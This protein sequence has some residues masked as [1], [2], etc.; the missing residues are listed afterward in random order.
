MR[1]SYRPYNALDE[2]ES[3]TLVQFTPD[4]DYLWAAGF[5]S[6]RVLHQFNVN[7]PGRDSR[8]CRLGKTR[9]S[10]DGQKGLVSAMSISKDNPNI[11]AIGTYAPG[12]I[13]IYD[14]RS[15]TVATSGTVWEGMSVVGHGKSYKR[16]K[17]R[18]VQ[19]VNNSNSNSVGDN[20]SSNRNKDDA[21]STDGNWITA[22]KIE[23]F[24]SK[25][26]TGV[27]Q[28]ELATDYTLY[29]ASRRS[30]V[31]LAWDVRMLS[32]NADYISQ[33]IHGLAS[34]ATQSTTN[35]KLE[36]EVHEGSLYVGG[37]DACVRIYDTKTGA[38]VGSIDQLP[39]T[40]NGVSFFHHETLQ[41]QW[42]AVAT[43]SRHFPTVDDLEQDGV[44]IEDP[45][46]EAGRLYL[47]EIRN[48][49]KS[50]EVG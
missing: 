13:Y 23:W 1:A 36:F 48:K 46:I 26:Q 24:Q 7:Q 27:T 15:G 42:L 31:I 14:N 50:L 11:M 49:S 29:S 21:D 44:P 38:M 18:F 3:P 19:I 5:R 25:A 39:D 32:G 40:A 45:S 9:R 2:M 34:Y 30:D 28:L 16:K 10:S 17:R 35:Q 22:A 43:G 20:D 37:Q 33:P 4:G 12:S 8:V 41:K 6:D 47:Y